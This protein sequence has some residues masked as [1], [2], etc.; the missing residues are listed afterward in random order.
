MWTEFDEALPV[1]TCDY[2]F[3]PGSARSL[4]VGIDGGIAIVSPPYRAREE[5]FAAIGRYGAVR[6]LVAPN[7]FHH[8]G[9]AE[10][11]RRFPDAQIYAPRQS[12]DRVQRKAGVAGIRP[13]ADLAALGGRRVTFTDMPHYK[14]GEALV[15]I[16]TARGRAW[17]VTDVIFNFE[18][19]PGPLPIR[20]IF[21][22]SGSAPGLR[23]NNIAP[24]FMV[25]DKRALMGW[26]AQEAGRD[27][28]RFLIPAH[29]AILDCGPG[30]DAVRRLLT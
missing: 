9:L 29:G 30:G 4:A 15:R 24:L 2:T 23:I 22:L 6:A 10:W 20:M 5:D 13:L 14:T 7:A 27:P 19:M 21:R 11:K 3:G 18:T 26:L 12:I 17:Y 1:L 8:L 25:Q 16:D 28:P